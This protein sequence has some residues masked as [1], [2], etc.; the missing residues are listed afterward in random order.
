MSLS[1]VLIF[2]PGRCGEVKQ[3]QAWASEAGILEFKIPFFL[4]AA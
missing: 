4:L 1:S 3:L 2:T